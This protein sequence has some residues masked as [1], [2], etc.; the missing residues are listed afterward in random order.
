[1]ELAQG[2]TGE[3]IPFQ[4][5]RIE[6]LFVL[7]AKGLLY[8]HWQSLLGAD[9]CAAATVLLALLHWRIRSSGV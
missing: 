6:S 8:F 4:S 1:M 9:D 2:Y 3:K 5:G 7:I